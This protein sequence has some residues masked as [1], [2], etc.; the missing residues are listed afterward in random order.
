METLYELFGEGRELNS[1]QMALRAVVV[2]FIAWL[3]LR[4]SGRR[5]FGF[6]TPL[7]NVTAILLGA[8]LS[9]A[10][11]GVSPFVPVVV[12]CLCIVVLHRAMAW[13]IVRN[14]RILHFIE[15]DK[16]LLYEKGNFIP[17]NMRR[18]LV[19]EEDILQ[20]LRKAGMTEQVQEMEKIFMERSGEISFVKKEN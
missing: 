9:R 6:R 3:L 11:T 5:S 1:L 15:G 2:F 8:V 16:I 7:D 17:G 18:A 20:G 19:G 13:T 4:I 10:V 12:A 14:K